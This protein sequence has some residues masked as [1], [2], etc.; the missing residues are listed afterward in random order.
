M[1]MDSRGGDG[2]GIA[3]DNLICKTEEVKKFNDFWRQD[4]V[5]DILDQPVIMGHDRRASVG[6]KTYNNTQ[7]IFFPESES[8][9]ICSILSHNGTLYNHEELLRKYKAHIGFEK[10]L[11]KMSDSQMLAIL[12]EKVGWKILDEYIGSASIV[13]M[14]ASEPGVMY[15]YHGRSK[16]TKYVQTESEERPLFY[17]VDNNQ[18]WFCSTKD[19]LTKIISNT[20]AICE[21]PFNA[22]FKIVGNTMTKVCDIDRSNA[23]QQSFEVKVFNSKSS[24]YSND[25]DEENWH[26][27]KNEH[28]WSKY[29]HKV[30][31]RKS[32]TENKASNVSKAEDEAVQLSLLPTHY[33]R[34]TDS[35]YW[36]NG[37]WVDPNDKLLHGR[38]LITTV[39]RIFESENAKTYLKLYAFY[40]W[41]GNLMLGRTEYLD[42]LRA[43]MKNPDMKGSHFWINY[44]CKGFAQPYYIP[45]EYNGS[46]NIL[47]CNKTHE[48]FSGEFC[49][50]FSS[51]KIT[52]K[53]GKVVKSQMSVYNQLSD[54]LVYHDPF[55]SDYDD[56]M[57][58]IMAEFH[59]DEKP[60]EEKLECPNCMGITYDGSLPCSVCG[61]EGI[62]SKDDLD[63]EI[64]DLENIGKMISS[65]T[66]EAF[67]ARGMVHLANRGIEILEEPEVSDYNN[68]ICKQ[69]EKVKELL[70]DGKYNCNDI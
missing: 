1:E 44:A 4:P 34:L 70:V 67:I 36:K 42:L 45:S 51:R 33:N 5:P 65:M 14:H 30:E 32:F 46:N 61:G 21:L 49:P 52:F 13:Y 24:Y 62:I 53:M 7:P 50:T 11:D 63:K 3:Y 18:L 60:I 16:N 2:C 68:G 69:L 6:A 38:V 26:G 35:I 19:A 39:G 66:D 27:K 28:Y 12:I 23:Y 37:V 22:V 17:G 20:E 43:S 31:N 64:A 56:E 10:E 29:G 25:S 15:V 8:V 59:E 40:F 54:I 55:P 41:R 48:P 47:F 9:K 58:K 57:K